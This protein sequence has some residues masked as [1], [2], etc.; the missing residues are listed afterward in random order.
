MKK[1]FLLSFILA[2][3][4]SL[5]AQSLPLALS[6][7]TIQWDYTTAQINAANVT[8]FQIAVV[9]QGNSI[10]DIDYKDASPVITPMSDGTG[11]SYAVPLTN[12]S[13]GNHTFAVRACNQDL[14]SDATTLDFRLTAKPGA[15]GNLRIGGK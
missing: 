11:N 10:S 4:L 3:T 9:N 7:S 5:A 8:K 13:V 15:V 1:I 14:C 12:V 6:T 2:F